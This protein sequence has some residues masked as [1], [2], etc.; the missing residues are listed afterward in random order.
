[1]AITFRSSSLVAVL[2]TATGDTM[3]VS[4]TG[5]IRGQE[6]EEPACIQFQSGKYILNLHLVVGLSSSYYEFFL[7]FSFLETPPPPPQRKWKK[8]KEIEEWT[9]FY[10]F[11]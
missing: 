4:P 11:K 9:S 1:M 2:S 3:A 10:V 7:C 8:K 5:W 6:G